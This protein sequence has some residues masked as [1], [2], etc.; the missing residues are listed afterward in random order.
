MQCG[1]G[2]ER[3]TSSTSGQVS[4]RTPRQPLGAASI[5]ISRMHKVI[6]KD[7]DDDYGSS[8]GAGSVAAREAT[9]TSPSAD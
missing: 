8:S 6:E 2:Q 7:E 3:G 4:A 9:T 5:H 1:E